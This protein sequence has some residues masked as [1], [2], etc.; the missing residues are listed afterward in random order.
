MSL[1]DADKDLIR[2][3]LESHNHCVHEAEL[4][5]TLVLIEFELRRGVGL[6]DDEI[7][8]ART[9]LTDSI[10]EGLV[11]KG[12]IEVTGIDSETGEFYIGL[13]ETGEQAYEEYYGK[14]EEN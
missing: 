14:K 12:M 1:S 8:L 9:F 7:E 10:V 13:T 2:L 3:S 11:L 5:F 6:D 4:C